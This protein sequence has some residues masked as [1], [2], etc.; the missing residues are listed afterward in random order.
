M[1]DKGQLERII[2]LIVVQELT[3]LAK[4]LGGQRAANSYAIASLRADHERE[5]AERKVP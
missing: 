3:V 1:T 2:R 4:A 5:A